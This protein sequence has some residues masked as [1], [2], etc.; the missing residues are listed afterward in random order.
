MS[1]FLQFIALGNLGGDPEMNKTRDGKAVCNFSLAVS[2]QWYDA[3]NQRQERT[4][5]CRVSVW[6]K[7]AE[8][9]QQYLSKGSKAMVIGKP[10]ARGFTDRNGEVRA[11]LDVVAR[12]VKFLSFSDGNQDGSRGRRNSRDN[13]GQRRGQY[14]DPPSTWDDIPF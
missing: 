13:Q 2:E 7:L 10:T 9:C 4:T 12:E 11:S 5:W 8:A 6:G 14:S 3:N 1:S